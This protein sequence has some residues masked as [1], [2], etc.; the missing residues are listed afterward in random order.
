MAAMADVFVSY[1]RK[2]QARALM[3]A[4]LLRREGWDVWWDEDIRVGKGWGPQIEAALDGAK[5]VVVLWT[6]AA[7]AS[8]W[9]IKEAQHALKHR[10]LFSVRLDECEVPDRFDAIEMALLQGWAG[11]GGGKAT[12][13]GER[14]LANLLRSLAERVMPSRIDTVRPGFQSRFLGEK[15][16]VRWPRV[17][18]VARQLHYLHFSV[19]INPARRLAWYVAYNVD[20]PA[21]HK[22]LPRRD[23]DHA[24]LPDPLVLA[25]LQPTDRHFRGSGFDR[26]HLASRRSVAWGSEREAAIASRQAFFWT[27]TAPQHRRLNTGSYMAVE[28]WETDLSQRHGRLVG[29]CGPVLGS[30]DPLYEDEQAGDDGFVALETFRLPQA[31][32]KVVVAVDARG[33]LVQRA[34]LFPNADAVGGPFGSGV[35]LAK[36]T[37]DIGALQQRTRI[38][39][40][41]EVARA[42]L[43]KEGELAKRELP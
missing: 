13:A 24:W 41:P 11:N 42:T 33:R 9:V 30:D 14:E 18:G 43:L 26:G 23:R 12:E 19:V 40:P 17:R 36:F 25:E 34:F 39:F 22:V 35:D 27:N 29:L 10:K 5:A 20:V 15:N 31:Y 4:E 16:R 8:R 1:S 3:F 38:E 28:K 21:A 2:D 37:I 7:C 32:W 6:K